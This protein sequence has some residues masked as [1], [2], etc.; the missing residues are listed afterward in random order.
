[1]VTFVTQPSPVRP[2]VE[3][4]RLPTV[5]FNTW[6]QTITDRSLI[7]GTGTPEGVISAS[8]G[9]EY[10]DD[11]GAAGAVRWVKRDNDDGLGDTTKGW[12]AY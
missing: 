10:M 2:T 6:V 11:A 5:E 9:A 12:I 4:N 7:I 8:Q 1:M 3:E